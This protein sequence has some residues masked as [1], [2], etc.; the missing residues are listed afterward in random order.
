MASVITSIGLDHTQWLGTTLPAIAGEK[1][2]IIKPRRP[3]YLGACAEAIRNVV[4]SLS[5]LRGS[6]C[7]SVPEIFRTVSVNWLSGSQNIQSQTGETFHLGLLGSRQPSNASLVRAVL[8]GLSNEFPVTKQAIR[9]G[10]ALVR[11]PARFE[12]LRV[13]AKTA[14]V[15]GAHNPQAISALLATLK[16]SPWRAENCRFFLGIIKDKDAAAMITILPRAGLSD[17]ISVRPASPRALAAR[18]LA[19][20]LRRHAPRARVQV[21]AEPAAALP[22]GFPIRRA[23]D[24]GR[25]RLA[26]PGGRGPADLLD[27]RSAS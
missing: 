4:S 11:W 13:G 22:A 2:G 8:D 15:D 20:L 9:R 10:L 19:A 5:V 27:L 7:Y 17:A 24:R 16:T 18:E 3:V 21:Q 25:V 14:V 1:A 12:V 6:R 26:L 23:Q